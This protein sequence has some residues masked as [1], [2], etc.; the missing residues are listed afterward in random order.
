S[1]QQQAQLAEQD[2]ALQGEIEALWK[3]IDTEGITSARALA[4]TELTR[5]AFESGAVQRGH[6]DGPGLGRSTLD[7][8][9]EALAAEPDAVA[10]LEL[11]RGHVHAWLGEH[12]EAAASY[13]AS[14]AADATM[15]TFLELLTLP[16][17]PAV[18]SAVLAACPTLRPQVD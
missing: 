17:S 5:R 1:A 18:D 7:H 9:G 12:D 15:S 6:V 11:A 3:E 16:R 14:L 8:L 4:L 10:S 2:R 13:T